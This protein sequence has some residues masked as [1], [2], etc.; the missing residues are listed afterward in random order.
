MKSNYR[1]YTKLAAVAI[2]LSFG[3]RA[4][5]E[6]PRDELA[7]AYYLLKTADH[8]YKGHKAKAI[9]EIE[10]AGHEIGMKFE[11][12]IS[13]HERQLKSDE[14]ISAASGLLRDARDKMEA[15]DRD[16]AA[17]HLQKAIEEVDA[18]LKAR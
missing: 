3:I 4:Y 15:S 1:L 14:Q 11:G 7:H 6:P 10:Q 16:K 9:H 8:D 2:A 12:H 13:D 18:A 17:T 5:A